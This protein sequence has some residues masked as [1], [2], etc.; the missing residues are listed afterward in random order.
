VNVT[1]SGRPFDEIRPAS[2]LIQA[3]FIHND[4]SFLPE[5]V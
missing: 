1:D 3:M 5:I 2:V 4:P